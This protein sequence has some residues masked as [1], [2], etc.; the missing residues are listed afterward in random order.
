MRGTE[1][2]SGLN[3]DLPC[4]FGEGNGV[5]F[6]WMEWEG[7]RSWSRRFEQKH[8]VDRLWY[9]ESN[10]PSSLSPQALLIPIG[11]VYRTC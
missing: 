7:G 4:V 5:E 8:V 1:T 2:G 3:S 10:T 11:S 9:Y 6:A